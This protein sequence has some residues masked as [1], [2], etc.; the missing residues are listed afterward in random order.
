MG[1]RRWE[2]PLVDEDWHVICQ[3][4]YR[5]VR[6]ADGLYHKFVEKDKEI[7]VR[8]P[9]G[10]SRETTL[11]E[12]T[13]A[14][15]RG[16]THYDQSYAAEIERREE[17]REELWNA[18][19]ARLLLCRRRCGKWSRG[20]NADSST[21]GSRS[22]FSC[23]SLARERRLA[24]CGACMFSRLF[25]S[26]LAVRLRVVQRFRG[27]GFLAHS[28]VVC[29]QFTSEEEWFFGHSRAECCE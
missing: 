3:A 28:V 2:R 18:H 1:P 19:L 14:N 25:S 11:W 21:A 12:L 29:F 17:V 5:G 10:S 6:G 15:D 27:C 4:I 7:N 24:P 9:S 20:K 13:E 8:N 26:C 16:D 22:G 23:E